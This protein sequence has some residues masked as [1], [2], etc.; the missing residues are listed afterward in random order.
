MPPEVLKVTLAGF[1][2]VFSLSAVENQTVGELKD[3][4]LH[5]T[6]ELKCLYSRH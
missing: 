2:K 6:E 3:P 1:T 4:N 5:G